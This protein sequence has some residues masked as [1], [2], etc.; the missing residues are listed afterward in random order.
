MFVAL[1]LDREKL[2]RSLSCVLDRLGSA[3]NLQRIYQS[4]ISADSSPNHEMAGANDIKAD[5][6]VF[7]DYDVLDHSVFHEHLKCRPVPD[8]E[9][10]YAGRSGVHYK[11]AAIPVKVMLVGV[12]G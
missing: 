12:S 7:T 5:R 2:N 6:L 8:T 4:M 10:L 9:N 11:S 3:L 1:F